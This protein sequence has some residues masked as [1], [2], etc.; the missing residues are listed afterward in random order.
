MNQSKR[1]WAWAYRKVRGWHVS[2]LQAIYRASRF[3]LTGDTGSFAS[4]GGWRKS[5][6]TR[7]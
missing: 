4:H 1:G 3:A 5:R 6:L 2:S 7:S